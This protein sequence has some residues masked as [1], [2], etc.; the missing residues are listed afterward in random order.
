MLI[1]KSNDLKK[2]HKLFSI[3]IPMYVS[4]TEEKELLFY[5]ANLHC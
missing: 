2:V 4:S 1:G 3:E 5:L